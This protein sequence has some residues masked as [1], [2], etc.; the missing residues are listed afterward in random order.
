VEEILGQIVNVL[1][2]DCVVAFAIKQYIFTLLL[3]LLCFDMKRVALHIAY[4][5]ERNTFFSPKRKRE[6]LL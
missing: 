2:F 3:P 5:K 6:P 4:H 1:L